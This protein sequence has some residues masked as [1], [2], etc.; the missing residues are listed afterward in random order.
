MSASSETVQD[1]I[2]W[3]KPLHALHLLGSPRPPRLLWPRPAATNAEVGEAGPFGADRSSS[4]FGA[5]WRMVA[6]TSPK[7]MG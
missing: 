5:M 7:D 2:I 1:D 4:M 6:I 3:S